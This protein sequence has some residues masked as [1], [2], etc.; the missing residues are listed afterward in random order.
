MIR[1]DYCGPTEQVQHP[2]QE[3][4]YEDP[5]FCIA[6]DRYR[7]NTHQRGLKMAVVKYRIGKVEH[8]HGYANG[9]EVSLGP[10]EG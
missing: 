7:M 1:N 3:V 2:R 9:P 8:E 6:C 10:H 4:T 5:H